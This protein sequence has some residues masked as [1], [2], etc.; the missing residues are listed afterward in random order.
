MRRALAAL[1]R[2]ALFATLVA[3]FAAAI[4]CRDAADEKSVPVVETTRQAAP[5]P[6]ATEFVD[7]AE[8]QLYFGDLHVHTGWSFDAF[9]HG[10]RTGP[11]DA[12]RFARGEA[13]PHA[14]GGTI[15]LSGPP[16]DFIAVTDHA[17][18]LGVANAGLQDAHPLHRQPLIQGW[19]GRD[20]GLQSLATQRL[21]NSYQRRRDLPRRGRSEAPVLGLRLGEPRGALAVD[22]RG[23]RGRLR[24]ARDPA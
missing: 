18:Y 10:V 6:R 19:L 12:Y 15:E 22:G 23:P 3:I 14:A 2:R 24:A 16:L 13:I 11:A 17:E 1:V 9:E 5:A 7:G 20:P 21:R 4:A 8:R